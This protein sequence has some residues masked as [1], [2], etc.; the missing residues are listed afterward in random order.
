MDKCRNKITI[1]L[2]FSIKLQTEKLNKAIPTPRFLDLTH[3]HTHTH[4]IK[5]R[6]QDLTHTHTHN[7][8]ILVVPHTLTPLQDIT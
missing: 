2:T 6:L 5:H 8:R 3:A 4:N 1:I 7:H